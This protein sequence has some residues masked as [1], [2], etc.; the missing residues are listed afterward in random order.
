[1]Q[2]GGIFLKSTYAVFSY[3]QAGSPA[4]GFAPAVITQQDLSTFVP[5]AVATVSATSFQIASIAPTVDSTVAVAT[6]DVPVYVLLLPCSFYM[7]LQSA[8]ERSILHPCSTSSTSVSSDSVVVVIATATSAA[9]TIVVATVTAKPTSAAAAAAATTSVVVKSA[10][11]KE[12]SIKRVFGAI[13]AAGA[14][15]AMML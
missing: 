7:M 14:L 11:T 4:V 15:A 13:A 10:A 3:S 6:F 9:P 12:R 1:M 2:I 5:T 8:D